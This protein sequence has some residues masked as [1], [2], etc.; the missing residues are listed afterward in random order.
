MAQS[1]S[2]THSPMM[3]QYLRIKADYPDKLLLYRMGD[4][5]EFFYDDAKHAA[6][7]LDLTLTS[8]GQSAG[9]PIPMA[10]VPFH[11]V[12]GYLLKLLQKGESVA[13]CEQIGD[14]ATSK[15]PVERQVTR[16][17]TPGTITDEA[18]LNEYQDNVLVAVHSENG[19]QFGI[20]ALDITNGRFCVC[21]VENETVLQ[22]ELQRLHPAEL[23]LAENQAANHSNKYTVCRRPIWDFDLKSNYKLLCEQ[24]S[25]QHLGGFGCDGLTLAIQ[26]AGA[27]LRYI[28]ITQCTVQALAHIQSLHVEN[29]DDTIFLDAT[30]QRNLE[31]I[32]NLQNKTD[33][34]LASVMDK[35]A[36]PMGNRLLKRWLLRPLRHRDTLTQRQ[37]AIR[38]LQTVGET[39]YDYLRK[40]GDM[41]R[42]VARISLRSARPRDLLQLRQ[43]LSQLPAIKKLLSKLNAPL[44]QQLEKSIDSFD[45]LLVTLQKAL[46]DNPPTLAREGGVIAPGYD[47]LLDELRSL[48]VNAGQFLIDLE[49]QE[50]ARTQLSSL[51]VGFNRV[52]GYYIEISKVQ[53]LQAPTNYMR[54][55]TLK[56]A[57]RFITP[58]LKSFEDKVLSSEEKALAREKILYDELLDTLLRVLKPLQNTAIALAQIDVLNNLAQCA[59]RL[60]WDCPT[61]TDKKEIIIEQGRH[62]VIEQLT[63]LPFIPND[64][65]L[66]ATR[67][68]LLITGPNMGGKSTYM[69]QT[70]LIVL[71]AHIGSFVPAKKAQIGK[72]DRIFTRIG[73]S[74]D[75]ASNR[76]TFMVE[77]TETATILH[78][79]TEH[80]LILL[81]EIGRGTSTFDGL[82]LAFACATY[83]TEQLHPY[84]LF[85]THY[86]ELTELAEQL[87]GCANIH[88]AAVEHENGIVFL[89]SVQ[90][91]A[92]SKSYGLQVAQ[93]AGIPQSVLKM[94]Q[95]KLEQLEA[96]RFTDDGARK[97]VIP[98][99]S[100]S[101]PHPIVKKIRH[102]SIDNL[103]PR[104]ALAVLYQL[105]G[106]VTEIEPS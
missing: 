27:L 48:H 21:E 71:L 18:L 101:E 22:S 41:E 79:A 19:Q 45:E 62:P 67:H 47:Q 14:P 8:R 36:T 4:F 84:V 73:A 44:L 2:T 11:A 87:A 82:S 51:K 53:A 94:A 32:T 106:L 74:D 80:S 97:V 92:A 23:L 17:V 46:V 104:E 42:I 93:L 30:T 86:F 81:D 60:H 98:K 95:Q 102:L 1:T 75:L 66:D 61:L 99:Q 28:Q 100:A 69:R 7:L 68:T 13:I 52:H 15:G 65:C 35:T 40:I 37:M 76:S 6:F 38:Q 59:M 31:L 88:L 26:A 25:T 90:E 91:G 56:N 39:L 3:Q 58:E 89:H 63:E 50:K 29:I 24:F 12:E 33:N 96:T 5:Y 103:T 70:A 64:I 83:L 16:I 49:T 54:R 43:A 105:Q 57:E 77:M 55:Q 9:E 10:G 20:A 85:A 34:T 72:V 78:H